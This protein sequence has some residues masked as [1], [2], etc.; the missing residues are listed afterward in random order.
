MLERVDELVDD[1]EGDYDQSGVHPG[2][3]QLRTID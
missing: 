1:V 3:D 2:Y